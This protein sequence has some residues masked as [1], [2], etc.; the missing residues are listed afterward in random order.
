[1]NLDVRCIETSTGVRKCFVG[2]FSRNE[3]CNGHYT[4]DFI[5]N[6]YSA[7]GKGIFDCR[8]NVLGHLQQVRQNGQMY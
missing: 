3:K 8:V 5:F 6:L 4:T 7:E 2:L 1:M